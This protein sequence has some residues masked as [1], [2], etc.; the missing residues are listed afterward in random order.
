[1]PK[2]H[3]YSQLSP[4]DKRKYNKKMLLLASSVMK[5]VSDNN[6][7]L[8]DLL[9]HKAFKGLPETTKTMMDAKHAVRAIAEYAADEAFAN[10]MV[11]KFNKLTENKHY[12]G[13]EE[14]VNETE[15]ILNRRSNRLVAKEIKNRN[16]T[17][18]AKSAFI[19][20]SQKVKDDM[21][22]R[23]DPTY[24]PF[25]KVSDDHVPI[26]HYG[27]ILGQRN[28]KTDEVIIN[29]DLVRLL[30]DNKLGDLDEE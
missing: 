11:T 2:S 17:G 7:E 29:P 6:L 26:S 20:R 21:F 22:D 9:K 30:E 23:Q 16:L 19:E 13:R 4:S 12:R 25:A 10:S 18:D 3:V 24:R 28:I 27:Q 5:N 1:M 8:A 14:D 15:R